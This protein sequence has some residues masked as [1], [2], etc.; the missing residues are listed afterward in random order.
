MRMIGPLRYW[1][2]IDAETGFLGAQARG[3]VGLASMAGMAF[4][5]WQL[6]QR[7][8]LALPGVLAWLLAAVLALT[9]FT[10]GI[11]F[12]DRL[13]Y[14]LF[15]NPR[16]RLYVFRGNRRRRLLAVQAA[17]TVKGHAL[18]LHALENTG[19]LA[20]RGELALPSSTMAKLAAGPSAAEWGELCSDARTV[21]EELRESATTLRPGDNRKAPLLSKAADLEALADYTA[22]KAAGRIPDTHGC[23]VM[24][25]IQSL[26]LENR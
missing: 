16:G 19:R 21:A 7:F 22:A 25:E 6:G 8:V 9:V 10:I 20:S 1:M 3:L 4:G 14:A 17:A 5:T 23:A 15:I 18:A 12:L 13:L 26:F 2:R 11:K 24:G